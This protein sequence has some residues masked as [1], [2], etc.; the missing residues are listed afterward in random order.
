MIFIRQTIVEIL[1]E[2][3]SNKKRASGRENNTQMDARMEKDMTQEEK[4]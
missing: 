4:Q 2:I 1:K 3:K